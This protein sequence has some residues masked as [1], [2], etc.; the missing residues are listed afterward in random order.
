MDAG[1]FFS[2]D[3]ADVG[4]SVDVGL[5]AA[6]FK[7]TDA[8]VAIRFGMVILKRWKGLTKLLIFHAFSLKKRSQGPRG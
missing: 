3:S 8:L 7:V 5:I 6:L 1:D 2:T 4:I